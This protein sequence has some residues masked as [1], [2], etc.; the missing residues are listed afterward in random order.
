[1]R[2]KVGLAGYGLSGKTF[3]LPL[4]RSLPEDFEVSAVAAGSRFEEAARE[5]PDARIVRTAEELFRLPG[6]DLAVIATPSGFHAAHAR[7]ALEAGLAV[8]LEK[9]FASTVREAE[10]L[11]RV[12]EAAGRTLAVFHNRRWDADFVT[13][14]GLLERGFLGDVSEAEF[15]WE[16]FRPSVQDRWKER[17]GPGSGLLW[18][19]GPHL[20]DQALRL[21]GPFDWVMADVQ[22]QRPGAAV[23][24]WFHAVLGA[25]PRRIV[26][27][28][29]CLAP[30]AGFHYRVLGA[31]AT[32]RT[33]GEDGQEAVLR[34]GGLPGSPGWGGMPGAGLLSRADG[35]EKRMD[36]AGGD[37]REFYR[38]LAAAL[39][40]RGPVPVDPAGA[41]ETLRLMEAARVSSETGRRVILR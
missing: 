15:R 26:L 37:W 3:H 24:D 8:V 35:S 39:A 10:T 19:L 40:G 1:M 6:L 12:S 23:D 27:H 17:E 9:P 4:I 5:L 31:T 18:D 2:Y 34:A 11:I 36:L 16:R 21:F 38:G 32:F 22:A 13:L 7:A 41:L 28:A 33:F 29:G 14:R 30:D 25:G 20:F